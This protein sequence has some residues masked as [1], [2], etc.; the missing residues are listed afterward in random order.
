MLTWKAHNYNVLGMA[1]S[2]DGRRLATCEKVESLYDSVDG[3][4]RGSGGTPVR[5][6]DVAERAEVATFEVPA[7]PGFEAATA[8]CLAFSRCG[9]YIAVGGAVAQP[10]GL[11][12]E[13]PVI[14]VWNA[15][16][17]A[18]VSPSLR[19][20]E[21]PTALAF[22]PG[23]APGLVAP[24]SGRL[25]HFANATDPGEGVLPTIH[26][27]A[28]DGNSPEASRV[29]VSPDLKW[30]VTNGRPRAVVWELTTLK[31]TYLRDHPR[32]QNHGPVAFGPGSDL[33][34]VG[35]GNGAYLWRFAEP[36]AKPVELKGHKLAVW[37]V[38]FTSDGT[39][40]Q[41]ASSD[42]TVRLWDV[43]TGKELNR[44]DFGIGKLY[45][46]AFSPDGLTCAAGGEGG[47]IVIWDVD[48]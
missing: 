37:A 9:Q 29:A 22:L 27:R 12:G 47:Q 42:G 16:T 21:T 11:P 6:W 13:H 34:A 17:G 3:R 20:P 26:D 48:D 2:P 25:C 40:V 8:T 1:Y 24:I 7:P 10:I 39:K 41:T 43:A 28:S 36:D 5:V 4:L 44:Y 31:P 46:A 33:V 14:R 19:P 35:R 15:G 32:S 30:V 23:A 45:C 18:V 38:G